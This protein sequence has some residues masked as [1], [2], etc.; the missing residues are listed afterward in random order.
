MKRKQLT[1][2]L[3]SAIMAVSACVPMNGISA[4]AAENAAESAAAESAGAESAEAAAAAMGQAEEDA[5]VPEAEK[6]EAEAPDAQAGA[7]DAAEDAAD[8]AA[9]EAAGEQEDVTSPGSEEQGETLPEAS[10]EEAEAP[11]GQKEA[12][13]APAGS[14]AEAPAGQN[15]PAE[16]AEDGASR[17]IE[18]PSEGSIEEPSEGSGEEPSEGSI[19]EEA[20]E[21]A[22]KAALSAPPQQEFDDAEEISAGDR[23][24]AHVDEEDAYAVWKFTPEESGIYSFFASSGYIEMIGMVYD[25]DH[26]LIEDSNGYDSG[27]NI[28][29]FYHQGTTYYLALQTDMST[30][31][32]ITVGLERSEM[33]DFYVEGNQEE[34]RVIRVPAGEEVTLSLFAQSPTGTLYYEWRDM[35]TDE[36]LG[37]SDSYTFTPD[38]RTSIYCF[39]ADGPSDNYSNSAYRY[40]NVCIENHLKAYPEGAYSPDSRSM[41][42]QISYGDSTTLKAIVSAD[43]DSQISYEWA[44]LVDK[45]DEWGNGYREYV[46][47][48]GADGSEYETEPLTEDGYYHCQITDQYD[49]GTDVYFRIHADNLISAYPEGADDVYESSAYLYADYGGSLTLRTIVNAAD[50]SK[51]KFHW[52]WIGETTDEYGEIHEEYVYIEGADTA[53]LELTNI[54]EKAKYSC[55]VEDQSDNSIIVYFNVSVQNHFTVKAEGSEEYEPEYAHLYAVP[56][57][58]LTLRTIVTADDDSQLQ[59]KWS[60]RIDSD[61]GWDYDEPIE[62]ADTAEYLIEEVEEAVYRC[63]V[64][65][66]YGNTETVTFYVYADNQLHAYP[67][68]GGEDDT[69][70]FMEVRPGETPTLR[71]IATAADMSRLTYQW[72]EDVD[73]GDGDEDLYSDI[74]GANEDSYQ[75][76]TTRKLKYRCEVSDQY[77]NTVY[78]Y[79]Y[80]RVNNELKMYP[81]GA[82]EGSHMVDIYPGLGDTVTLKVNA[83]AI[84]DSQLTYEWHD[85]YGNQLDSDGPELV[86]EEVTE[87]RSYGCRVT[88]QYQ[89]SDYAYFYIKFENHLKAYPAGCPDTNQQSKSA[90]PNSPLALKVVAEADDT[91]QL[92]YR[93]F[94]DYE[95]IEGEDTDTYMIP[96]VEAAGEYYC[97]V[98]DQYKNSCVVYFSVAVDNDF[99]AY[100]EGAEDG[101]EYVEMYVGYGEP[102]TLKI[103]TSAI[104]EEGITYFWVSNAPGGMEDPDN[105]KSEYTVPSVTATQTYWVTLTDAYGNSCYVTFNIYVENHFNVYPEGYEGHDSAY[106]YVKPGTKV[107]LNA[108]VEADDKEGISGYW[109]RDDRGEEIDCQESTLTVDAKNARYI[110]QAQDKYGNYKSAMFTL[111]VENGF[112]A[113]PEGAGTDPAGQY[114]DEA[115]LTPKAGEKLD[116]NVIATAE[117]GALSYEWYEN[118][119]FETSW[120]E[121]ETDYESIFGAGNSAALQVTADKSTSYCCTVSDEYGNEK[122]VYFHIR[123]GEVYAY[124]EGNEATKADRIAITAKAGQEMTLRTIAGGPEGTKLTYKWSEGPLN[125]SGWWP[126][127]EGVDDSK[128]SLT[129][130]PQASR[131]YLCVVTDQYQNQAMAYFYVNVNGMT[132]TTNHGKPV[133]EGDNK[134]EIH[135]P[136]AAGESVTL[137]T[138]AETE[139]ESGL[140]YSW[141]H[142]YYS[143]GEEYLDGEYGDSITVKAGDY[144]YYVS[145]IWDESGNRAEVRYYVDIDNKLTVYP[146]EGA[147]NTDLVDVVTK[148]GEK[149]T[150]KPVVSAADLKGIMYEWFDSR[151]RSLGD[152]EDYI[153]NVTHE[154]VIGCTVTDRFGNTKT[155]YYNI[156]FSSRKDLSTAAVTL[157]ESSYTYDGKEKKPAVTVTF[158]GNKLTEGTD[159]TVAY[160]DNINAGQAK[161]TVTAAGEYTGSNV[162]TFTIAKAAQ[163]LSVDKDALTIEAGGTGTITATGNVNKLS[164]TS[165]NEAAATVDAGGKVTAV[166]E[167]SAV[168]TVAAQGSANYESAEVTVRV[169]VTA[170]IVDISETEITVTDV[171]YSGKAQV[172]AVSVAYAGNILTEGTDYTVTCGQNINAGKYT[173]TVSGTGAFKGSTDKEYNVLKAEQELAADDI[174]LRPYET[175]KVKVTGAQGGLSYKSG[176]AAVATVANDGTVTAVAEGTA[177]IT[178]A[179]AE[180]DNYKSGTAQLEVTVTAYDLSSDG[181]KVTLAQ[182]AAVYSGKEIK[183][184]VTVKFGDVTLTEGTDYTVSYENNV[185]VGSASVT[186]KGNNTTTKN[187]A[188]AAFTI[189][190][191]SQ[192]ISADAPAEGLKIKVGESE[193]VT[194]SGAQGAVT[195]VSGETGVATVAADG[196]GGTAVTA[197]VTAVAEGTTKITISAAETENYKAAQ[198]IEIAVQVV[199]TTIDVS[200]LEITV[201]AAGLVYDGKEK[202]PEVTVKSK[203]TVLKEGFTVKY[204]NNVNAGLNTAKA[205]VTG[206][207]ITLS[208]TKEVAFSILPGK[209]TRGDMFN[210]ANNV[211][212]TWKEVP[213]AV[214]YKVYRSGVKD[215][216]IVTSGLVGWDK[217]PGLTNGHAYRYRV[218]ASL[219]GKGDPSGDSPLSYSKLMYRLKTVVI[220]S[221]KNTAPGKVTVKYDRTT[222]GDSYVLQYCERQDMVGAKTKVVLGAANTSYV[223]GGLKKGKTYYISIRVRKKVSGI[224]YYTTFGVAKKVTITK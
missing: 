25:S 112:A 193:K 204:E 166:A 153:L 90:A 222:S 63:T 98:S 101:E 179:A 115:I 71:V 66:R 65:D 154:D 110:Y 93:W 212:V 57:S 76:D 181:C 150:L 41:E 196:A 132:I 184:A 145:L 195:F 208:G 148:A 191:A 202:T 40:F 11:A 85:E 29:R 64:S 2:I 44:R 123:L 109:Y 163:P 117:E 3:L 19:E 74:E 129:V 188:A 73:D 169:T 218:V 17:P 50:T 39:V 100:P 5:F 99:T 32:T 13:D 83:T 91:S 120:G 52:S 167:G 156:T 171:T 190:K 49:N 136:A 131:R 217:D 58:S 103:I 28:E 86:V 206:D 81:E 140:S 137:Q 170:R 14:A 183:P 87:A 15:T 135:V 79:F 151:E 133:L 37:T 178:I 92:T 221:A 48:S 114:F 43:D 223:I 68:G 102:V 96:S 142:A 84:D 67:E 70:R 21:A 224:D 138:I 46:T 61:D 59:F 55:L 53:E 9:G 158:K 205:I 113:Y 187:S 220:R 214:Y 36:T 173:V 35:K 54:A 128:D 24:E 88:D 155:V 33:P 160:S 75:A 168:I 78:V 42:R 185:N 215:P 122:D 152:D 219:T 80:I 22:G 18:E 116:L 118:A 197:T 6:E 7:E 60:R 77:G 149:V 124:P 162:K 189:E 69:S 164:F 213:G 121:Y 12:A 47:I 180:T 1:A 200:E 126:L 23:K 161:V 172:P 30:I 94:G 111:R 107:T 194:V 174:A 175:A 165:S 199:P 125:D 198:A 211:K 159:Y 146:E 108:V 4:V 186:I 95:R 141:K 105:V 31:A 192:V 38:K 147:E 119:V 203:G 176:A 62:G 134:Y 127:E 106:L 56:G 97:E 143:Y 209:T 210:L 182:T 20:G 10:E 177:T 8:E 216:V 45:T 104:R 72:Q 130:A 157:S 34:T 201:D 16:A 27:F 207:N 144:P 26:Y 82:E 89:N 51:L 139:Q